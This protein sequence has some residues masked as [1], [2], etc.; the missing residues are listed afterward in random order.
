MSGDGFTKLKGKSGAEYVFAIVPRQTAFQAKPGVY[1]LAREIGPNRYSFCFVGQ[2]GDLSRRP[3]NP[4]KTA[5]FDRFGANLIFVLEEVSMSKREQMVTD[6]LQ[7]FQPV[8]NT[9]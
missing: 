6:L 2:S 4:D 8:C 3:L 1:A 7:A 5:C 9:Q